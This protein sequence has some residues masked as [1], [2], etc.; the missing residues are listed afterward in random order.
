VR[1][2]RVVPL[3]GVGEVAEGDDLATLL[4]DAVGREAFADGDV[5]VVAHK[6]VSKA[7]GR[8]VAGTD[9]REVAQ[10]E[11]VRIL[12]RS[13]DTLISETRHG[14]VCANAG[15][16]ASNVEGDRVA[17]LP[18][19]PDLSARR[20]RTKIERLTGARVA[21]IVSDTFGRAWRLGQSNVAIGIAGLDPFVDYR[22]TTDTYGK[23][24]VATRICVAD[25]IAGAAELVMGKT[26]GIFAAIVRG[27]DVHF[28]SGRATDVVRPHDEDLFR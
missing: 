7:E 11:S 18:L 6:V 27:L 12:R 16:D 17:L 22:G 9:R 1:E 14:F 8:V 25:E 24:L 4:V 26:N 19:D 5:V 15:V 20:V 10:R 21:V 13:R 2:L 23:D 28:G 3:E